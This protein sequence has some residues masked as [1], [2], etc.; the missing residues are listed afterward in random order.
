M[1]AS[2]LMTGCQRIVVAK[3]RA[4]Q[5]VTFWATHQNQQSLQLLVKVMYMISYLERKYI[6]VMY[7][8]HTRLPS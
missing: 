5:D 4:Q 1:I 6:Q 2:E 7:E 8:D 3:C